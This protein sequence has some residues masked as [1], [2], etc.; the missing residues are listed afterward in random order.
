MWILYS[1]KCKNVNLP[2]FPN[3]HLSNRSHILGGCLGPQ[4]KCCWKKIHFR[5][6]P[7]KPRLEEH[8]YLILKVIVS[9]TTLC[10][11]YLDIF[12]SSMPF[13]CRVAIKSVR[14]RDIRNCSSTPRPAKISGSWK[15][16]D[17]IDLRHLTRG[18]QLLPDAWLV[19]TQRV[20][21]L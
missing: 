16:V 8:K 20:S 10:C 13:L 21:L 6:H 17:Q 15:K 3:F 1:Q 11:T 9:P 12:F 5:F 2:I 7:I 14:G 4:K 18:L 19:S